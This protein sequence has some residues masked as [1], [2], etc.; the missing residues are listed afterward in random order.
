MS[1]PIR[2]HPLHFAKTTPLESCVGSH[3]LLPLLPASSGVVLRDHA[4]SG[5][6]D[7]KGFLHNTICREGGRDGGFKAGLAVHQHRK[8]SLNGQ[9]GEGGKHQTRGLV[10]VDSW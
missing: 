3:P 4:F 2:I 8:L 9:E 10:S 6:S 1:V 7:V 5:N